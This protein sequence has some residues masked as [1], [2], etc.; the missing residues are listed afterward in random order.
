LEEI[1]QGDSVLRTLLV[2]LL[3]LVAAILGL[4]LLAALFMAAMMAG[5]MGGGMMGSAMM[6]QASGFAPAAAVGLFVAL[7]VVGLALIVV[8]IA[9][10]GKRQA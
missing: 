4:L 5:M 3:V 10:Q 7:I 2:V 9:R 8:W 1:M 6:G